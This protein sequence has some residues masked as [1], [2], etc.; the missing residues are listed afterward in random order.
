[1]VRTEYIGEHDAL[2]VGFGA[3]STRLDVTDRVAVQHALSVW[4]N[5]LEV[6]EVTGYD[7]MSDPHS[8]ETW[9]MSRP[10]Q[11]TRYLAGQQAPEGVLHFAGGGIANLWAGFIDGAIETGLRVAREIGGE[12]TFTQ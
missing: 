8:R 3:D 10:G 7:W 6:L 2:L 11:V 12:L 9:L 4:R 5:D 1:V